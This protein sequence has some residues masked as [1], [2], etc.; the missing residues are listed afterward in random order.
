MCSSDLIDSLDKIRLLNGL[1]D[2]SMTLEHQTAIEAF[3]QDYRKNN[4]WIF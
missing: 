3:E 4:R 1:D 2:I